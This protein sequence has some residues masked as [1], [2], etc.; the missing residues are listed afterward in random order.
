MGSFLRV[1][2]VS[3]ARAQELG[4]ACPPGH[5][6]GQRVAVRAEERDVER[7]VVVP[8][9][10]LETLP[11]PAPR[12]ALGALDQAELFAERRRVACG[13]RAN[14]PGLEDVD[15]DFEVTVKTCELGVL[16]IASAFFHVPLPVAGTWSHPKTQRGD[17]G[18]HSI[19]GAPSGIIRR[20]P[21]N[22]SLHPHA[23]ANPGPCPSLR[24]SESENDSAYRDSICC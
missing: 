16:T 3:A 17:C 23:T 8:V 15:A 19:G 10:P 6:V 9:V 14:A 13:A 5:G 11:P 21:G 7:F 2:C 24:T 22:W 20:T 18:F 4:S 1:P 12:T